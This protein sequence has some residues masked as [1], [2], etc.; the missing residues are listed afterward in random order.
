MSKTTA[1][2]RHFSEDGT[3]LY[4]GISNS[5]VRRLGQHMRGARWAT[6]IS[7]VEV[8]Q[9]PSRESALA[10]EKAA[11]IAE[12]PLWNK[13]HNTRRRPEGP[14]I[15]LTRDALLS[16]YALSIHGKRMLS[17]CSMDDGTPELT[18]ITAAEY[19]QAFGYTSDKKVYQDLRKGV[20]DLRTAV[21]R[22][23]DGTCKA[24]ATHAEY[25]EGACFVSLADWIWKG[26]VIRYPFECV[27]QLSSVN[28][29][30]FLEALLPF[31]ANSKI[32]LRHLR[33]VIGP[34]RSYSNSY[35]DFR[36]RVIEP[37]VEN[38][39]AKEGLHLSWHA[40]KTGRSVTHLRF[41]MAGVRVSTG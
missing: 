9:Y 31:A 34:S 12:L 24:I 38:L 25:R 18:H 16:S 39:C 2:Y 7:R 30:R 14:S 26:S 41:S 17:L 3:L 21:A 32:P 29:W 1:L 19:M 23:P 5:A 6:E 10:A 28:H 11:I 36:K 8:S 22:L 4:V 33:H 35:K 37:A 20:E 13:V 27:A 15:C 40:V